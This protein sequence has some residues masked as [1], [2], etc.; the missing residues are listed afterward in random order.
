M[1]GKD[2]HVFTITILAF[3]QF[4]S[5]PKSLPYSFCF[6]YGSDVNESILSDVYESNFM[7]PPFAYLHFVSYEA[8]PRS[9]IVQS[10]H[11]TKHI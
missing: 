7:L 1:Y 6:Q 8:L 11:R 3:F 2:D 9:V 5:N 4:D 10:Q